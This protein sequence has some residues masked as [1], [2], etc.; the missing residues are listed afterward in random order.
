MAEKRYTNVVEMMRNLGDDSAFADGLAHDLAR[1]QLIK[2]LV[3]LAPPGVSRNRM[4]PRRL[5]SHKG[6][7]LR[8]KPRPMR[9]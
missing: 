1:K 4:S 8:W 2:K 9:T 3:A 5:V 7:S 6:G